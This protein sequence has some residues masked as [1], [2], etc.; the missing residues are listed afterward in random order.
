MKVKTLVSKLLILTVCSVIFS[1]IK[2]QRIPIE[3][4]QR[5][6]Q[7]RY[8]FI[9][10]SYVKWPPINDSTQNYWADGAYGDLSIDPQKG[11]LLVSDLANKFWGATAIYTYFTDCNPEG[12]QE[13]NTYS[14]TK[15][16]HF[17]DSNH[18]TKNNYISQFLKLESDITKLTCIK[19]AGKMVNL[20][21]RSICSCNFS[22]FDDTHYS[23]CD[24]VKECLTSYYPNVPYGFSAQNVFDF[25]P[26]CAFTTH[27]TSC[28]EIGV[29]EQVAYEVPGAEQTYY[30]ASLSNCKGNVEA[31]LTKYLAGSAKLFLLLR[32]YGSDS[33]IPPVTADGRFHYFTDF[34]VGSVSHTMPLGGSDAVFTNYCP[35]FADVGESG[36]GLPENDQ[37]PNDIVI[38]S[39]D[40][41]I[42]DGYY[43]SR[44]GDDDQSNCENPAGFTFN[45]YTGN[46]HRSI[47]D[48]EVWGSTGDEQLVWKRYSNSRSGDYTSSYGNVHNWNSNYQFFMQ[49]NDSN[50][51]K[52]A[53]VLIHYPEGGENIYTQDSIDKEMWL[54]PAG[55]GKKLLQNS[56]T[57]TL[58]MASGYRYRFERLK[59]DT[60]GKS[61][62]VLRDFRDAHQ[63]L[64]KFT[65]QNDSLLTQV[66]EPAGRSLHITY[67]TINGMP[68]IS[69]VSSSDGRNV[70]YQYNVFTDDSAKT[71]VSLSKVMYG[72]STKATYTYIQKKPG[73]HPVLEHAVDP[74]LD[75]ADVDMRYVYDTTREDGY[76][77][78]EKNGRTSETMAT[79][80]VSSDERYVCY[81]NGRVQTYNMPGEQLGQ[82]NAYT[83]GIGRGTGYVY[84]NNGSGFL[85]MEADPSGHI[86]KYDSL[87]AF[88]NTLQMTLPDGSNNTWKRDDL[89][90]VLSFTDELGRVT[91]YKRDG[92]HR[93][94]RIDY[95]DSSFEKFSYNNFGEVTTHTLRNKA[96]EI[97][98]YD[99][100]GL[101][102]SFKDALGNITKYA[103]D[104]FDRLKSVTDARN[105]VTSFTYNERGLVTKKKNADGSFQKYAYDSVGN[106]TTVTDELNHTWKTTYDEFKRPLTKTDP[107]NHKT[108]YSYNLVSPPSC[109]CSHT[110]NKPTKIVLPGGNTTTIGYDIEWEKTS[111][112]VAAGTKDS[113]TTFYEYDASGNLVTVID[114]MQKEW[115]TEY[116]E[117]NR[118]VSATTPLG[119]ET[120]WEYDSAGNVIKIIRPD[121][122]VIQNKYDKMNRVIQTI[123]AKNEI[124]N[125]QYD[126]EGNIT[127]ITDADSNQYSF[128]YDVLNRRTR[129]TYPDNSFERYTYDSV[130]NLKTYTNRAGNVSSY[131]YDKR[132]RQLSASWND[133]V[134][135]SVTR[136]YDAAGR[137]AFIGSSVSTTKYGY[138]NAN[139]LTRDTEIVAGA[140]V[141]KVII[142]QYNGDGLRS[143]VTYPDGTTISYAYT[144]RN[145]LDSIVSAASTVVNYDYDL[146]GNRTKKVLENGTNTIYSYDSSDRMLSVY[147]QKANVRFATFDYGYDKLD[148]RTFVKRINGKGD[149]YSYDATDQ[150]TNVLYDASNPDSIPINWNTNVTSVYDPSGNRAQQIRNG[151]T[152]QYTSNSL[153]E[154]IKIGNNTLTYTINGNLKTNSGWAYTYDAMNRMVTASKAGTVVRFTYDALNRCIKR[155]V[156]DTA[157]YYIYDGW[158]LI[159]ERNA[160]DAELQK[161]IQGAQTDEILKKVSPS[162]TVYYHY[163]ALGDVAALTGTT[164]N[165]VEQYIYGAYGAFTIKTG[166]GDTLVSSA[167]SNRFLFTGREYLK[168][169]DLYDYR[170]R[171]YSYRLGRF[172]QPDPLGFGGGDVNIYRYVNNNVLNLAD[173]EGLCSLSYQRDHGSWLG[174]TG[175]YG[176]P[177]WNADGWDYQVGGTYIGNV[178]L[179]NPDGHYTCNT[180]NCLGGNPEAGGAVTVSISGCCANKVYD[181][182]LFI[183]M[184][185]YATGS[186]KANGGFWADG[187]QQVTGYGSAKKGSSIS[188]TITA[189]VTTDASGNAYV[190]KYDQS[191][192]TGD[193]KGSWV[194]STIYISGTINPK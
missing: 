116:D 49:E 25:R 142:Y 177:S 44:D 6:F 3:R 55:V 21:G 58:Q 43:P 84:D 7:A 179:K 103:Y 14:G 57:F 32:S 166:N 33:N 119:D 65:Y 194:S 136:N 96:Q 109:G 29:R 168:D 152:T 80:T 176:Q 107:L 134:T 22:R 69:K 169:I 89:D 172:L 144:R 10:K 30:L 120:Q 102:T 86:T 140:A 154:Y 64:Y 118:K 73:A 76:I 37:A 52:Q 47:T 143:Q 165:M 113:A 133:G 26:S 31:D 173:A 50:L 182:T 82:L 15:G 83:D 189:T 167:Y 155:T 16:F 188:K 101:K 63:N 91:T 78:E 97:N 122:S 36:W 124:T 145:Q 93:V 51:F 40:F 45:P 146:D 185:M 149:V 174:G 24:Q 70:S 147:N 184:E 48:L 27:A 112:T 87:T 5:E 171:M 104:A 181:V 135:P 180:I 150:L 164:G 62:Y 61:R 153:N 42:P 59:K 148:R 95:P 123:D 90:Q 170:N 11:A 8:Y 190:G 77:K 137:L 18:V 175:T 162:N 72:D 178:T 105:N 67:Q 115:T 141:N 17:V 100:R 191:V 28:T 132:N 157:T 68:V 53:Q 139:E 13:I 192:V 187:K 114:P 129:M 4:A 186:G 74:R 71:W 138:D 121:G 85:R 92:Q 39:P 125:M 126:V 117:R 23:T 159:E 163:D 2:A 156:N 193:R 151:D 12:L 75:A 34:Q 54:P 88:G 161:Y 1:N 110:E 60:S 38:V 183:N 79:L 158:N 111:E 81:P 9:N 20:V 56:D 35:G 98:T 99:D 128:K 127:S 106:R 108:K 160:A 66:T 46:V 19:N 131:T 130:S 41:Q 94:L